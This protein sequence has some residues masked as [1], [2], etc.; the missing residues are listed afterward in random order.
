[1]FAIVIDVVT[2]KIKEGTLH[3]K[4]NADDFVLIAPTMTE[5]QEKIIL[6]KVLLRVNTSK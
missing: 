3:E 2:K 1:M 4:L 5:L 6:G